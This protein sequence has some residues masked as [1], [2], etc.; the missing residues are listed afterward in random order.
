MRRWLIG[1]SFAIAAPVA[2]QAQ[3]P[4]PVQIQNGRVEMRTGTAIDRE[5]A[6]VSGPASTDPV[7]I[8][9]RAPMIAGDRDVCGWY[10]DR[11]STVRGSF[12]ED[13][14]RSSNPPSPTGFGGQ[15]F[16]VQSSPKITPPTGPVPLEA[17]TQIVVLVRA[18]GGKVERLRSVADDCPM[19]A[20][21]R[22]V[23]WLSGVTG[24]ESVRFLGTLTR[25]AASDRSMFESEREVASGAVRAIGYHAE[26]SADAFLDQ[27]AGDHSD[28]SVR[29]QAASSLATSR[30]EHGAATVT[31]LIAAA[32]EPDERR[33]LTIALGQSHEASAVN[34][35]RSLTRDPDAKVRAEAA[36]YFILRGGAAAIQDALALIASDPDDSVRRRAV[37]G[38]ARLSGNAG[39]PS[40]IQLVR[41]SQNATVRKEAV[42]AL[43]Q[44][45]DPRAIALMEELL[46]R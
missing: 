42:S 19:D 21:G 13:E 11:Q 14:L 41:T 4:A 18:I 36:Y 28:S 24:A 5:I 37:N 27:V 35:L 20:G 38:L 22:T 10:I 25:P 40:L 15:A 43:S 3:L 46:K 29:H 9:W 30:G 44:S 32:K 39:V 33:S 1:I 2:I 12:V 8:A 26:A 23:Y 17:G 6:A 34:T 7:W 16:E 45:K 31:R